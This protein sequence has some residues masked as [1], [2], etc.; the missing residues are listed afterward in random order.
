MLYLQ[1]SLWGIYIRQG[2]LRHAA[3]SNHF[4]GINLVGSTVLAF[5]NLHNAWRYGKDLWVS[6]NTHA[7]VQ[8]RKIWRRTMV[9]TEQAH[10][11]ARSRF[12]YYYFYYHYR[13]KRSLAYSGIAL[14][15]VQEF[16]SICL[17]QLLSQVK[18]SV[19]MYFFNYFWKWEQLIGDNFWLFL[20]RHARR[21]NGCNPYPN[22]AP[23]PLLRGHNASF[24]RRTTTIAQ[25]PS[26]FP[27]LG[28]LFFLFSFDKISQSKLSSDWS[29]AETHCL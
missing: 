1:Q 16:L 10:T 9:N 26:F 4:C 15:T 13:A 3:Y 22:I 6:K 8:A 25:R 19:S 18:I 17:F 14:I 20:V 27:P 2:V 21:V 5:V 28:R 12:L 7:D 23:V 11:L 29:S 24:L